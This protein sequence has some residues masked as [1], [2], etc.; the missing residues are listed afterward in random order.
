[1]SN[2]VG[3]SR[4]NYFK[5]KD[6]EAFLDAL[7]AFEVRVEPAVRN[8]EP[9]YMLVSQSDGGD[10]PS[11]DFSSE[12]VNGDYKEIWFPGIVA[13]HL[14]DGECAIFMS[15]GA[16]KTRYVTGYAVAIVN[17][18]RYVEVNLDEIYGKAVRE[19]GLEQPPTFA[20]Y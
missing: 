20:E 10:W 5:V 7:G 12:D 13:P 19:L 9:L 1:M 15:V 17:D 11:S 2:W 3:T 4:T 14:A 16:E 8:D 18:G 6:K